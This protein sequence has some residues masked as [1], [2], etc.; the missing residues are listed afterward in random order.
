VKLLL[1]TNVLL[2]VLAKRDPWYDHS[3][4]VLSLAESEEIQGFLAAHSVSTLFYLSARH[5]GNRRATSVLVELLRV[6]TVA[7]LDHDTILRGLAL[8]WSDFEDALQMLSGINVDADYL[9]TRNPGDFTAASLSVVTP[10]EL[11]ALLS[12]DRGKE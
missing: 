2:D 7:P 1:D 8:G 3:A 10:T 6:L 9:V 12:A 4:T 11:L 5:L